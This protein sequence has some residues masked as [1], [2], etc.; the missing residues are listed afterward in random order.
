MASENMKKGIVLMVRTS[1]TQREIAK[2]LKV[3]ENT[4]SQWKKDKEFD[5]LRQHEERA[6]LGDLAAEA[7]RTMKGL[8]NAKS[9]LVRYNAASDILDRTG[10]KA[11]DKQELDINGAVQF[12]DDIGS[13]LNDS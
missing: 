2:E 5:E 4:V 9:E 10:Y 6:F 3:N 11:T 1:L 13:V 12:I 7:L 8:L